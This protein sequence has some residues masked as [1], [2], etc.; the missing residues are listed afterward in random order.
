M[1]F[2][3][4]KPTEQE[5]QIQKT[6]ERLA[7]ASANLTVKLRSI[8]EAIAT[9]Q[10]LRAD[11]AAEAEQALRR[12]QDYTADNGLDGANYEVAVSE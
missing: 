10:E 2:A 7:Q 3:D 11:V 6:W 8:D 1:Y 12:F 4:Y 5:V 9:L